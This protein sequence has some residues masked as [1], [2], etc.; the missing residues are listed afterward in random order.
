MIYNSLMYIGKA[1]GIAVD[2][3]ALSTNLTPEMYPSAPAVLK[4][5]TGVKSNTVKSAKG[6]APTK[7][8]A[9]WYFN[10]G[11]SVAEIGKAMRTDANPLLPNT[12]R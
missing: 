8:R 7:M 9:L 2:H 4:D 11:R 10:M 6:V 12:V 3:A 1:R 5:A